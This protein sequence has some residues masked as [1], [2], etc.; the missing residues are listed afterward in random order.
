MAWMDWY[1]SPSRLFLLLVALFAISIAGQVSFEVQE[2]QIAIESIRVSSILNF[3]FFGRVGHLIN[4]ISI[5]L[6]YF[7]RNT[8]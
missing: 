7:K 8:T 1:Q 2:D 4:S 3:D 6:V 5:L